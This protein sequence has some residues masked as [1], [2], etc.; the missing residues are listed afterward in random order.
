MK[1]FF[2]VSLILASFLFLSLPSL[3]AQEEED[4]FGGLMHT[5]FPAISEVTTLPSPPQPKKPTVVSAKITI[6]T[7]E[8]ETSIASAQL[9]Y[10]IDGKEWKYVEMKVREGDIYTAEIPGFP[11]GTEVTYYISVKDV[12]G[13]VST[14][15][16]FK[17]SRAE[18]KKQLVQGA[19]DIDNSEDIV[20]DDLDILD[21]KVGYDDEYVYLSFTV[22]GKISGGTL[23]PPYIHLQ[24]AKLT[25]PDVDEGEGLMVGKLL[26]YAPLALEIGK[27]LGAEKELGFPIPEFGLLD[28]QKLIGGKTEE[29]LV[30]EAEVEVKV[31]GDA[32][33]ARL[34][35]KALGENPS[36]CLRVIFVTIANASIDNFAPIPMNC[37]PYTTIYLRAHTYKL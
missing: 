25:N 34:K 18:V 17:T 32:F 8:E 13:N 21:T 37:S 2:L 22:Q 16:P 27:K 36:G 30:K 15:M 26:A 23:D 5:S 29:G 6:S 4:A 31:E 1:K 9:G 35:R 33:Y 28:I 19:K 3:Y 7:E 12:F 11:A 10:S 24:G 14:E 20:K